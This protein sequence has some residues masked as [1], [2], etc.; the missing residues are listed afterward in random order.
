M[1]FPA[2]QQASATDDFHRFLLWEDCFAAGRAAIYSFAANPYVDEDCRALWEA[3]RAHE[4][5]M[6]KLRNFPVRR[7]DFLFR[8]DTA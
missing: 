6:I 1:T 2:I 8:L 3:G 7:E 4:I 5:T